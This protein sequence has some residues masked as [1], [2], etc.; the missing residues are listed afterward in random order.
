MSTSQ[1]FVM[2]NRAPRVQIDCDVKLCSTQKNVQLPCAMGPTAQFTVPNT[3]TGATPLADIDGKS[4]AEKEI[5][6]SHDTARDALR[7]A[8]GAQAEPYD[9][10]DSVLAELK[11]THVPER[12]NGGAILSG[13]GRRGHVPPEDRMDD[14]PVPC[15]GRPEKALVG[16]DRNRTHATPR[17]SAKLADGGV[18]AGEVA[19]GCTERDPEALMS[20]TK[21]RPSASQSPFGTVSTSRPDRDSLNRP[22]L[23]MAVF[24]DFSGRAARGLRAVG[25]DLAARPPILLDVDTVEDVIASFAT[26]LTLPI[27]KDGARIEVTLNELDDLHP[28]ELYDSVEIFEALSG[29][30]QQLGTGTMAERAVAQLKGWSETYGKP[31]QLPRRSAA[32]SVPPN[33]KLSDFQ[34]LIGD[35][36]GELTQAS[37]AEDLIARIVGPHVLK[38]PDVGAE[39]MKQSVDEALSTAMRLLLH[40]PDFQ[41]VESQ[42]RALDLMA[43]RIETGSDVEIVLYDISAEELAMDL[44]A[45]EDLSESGIFRL[46]TEALESE[47]GTGGFSALLGLYTLEETPPHA[48]L[49]AR[50]G[51]VAA[52][53]DAPFFAAMTPAYLETAKADRHPLVIQAW[54]ALRALPE[55]AYLGLATPRFLL[56]Q[57]YG[58]K[59][60]PCSSFNFEEFTP[61]EG[62]SGMLW[63]NPVVLVAILLAATR[64]KDGK[65][66]D[67]GSVMSLDDMPFH[68]FTDRYG[69]QIALPCTERN[70]T[71][72]P[73][74]H[75]LARGFMPVFW[76]KGRNEVRLGS[77]RA[78]S[79]D[80]IAGPW[81]DTALTGKPAPSASTLEMDVAAGA[82]ASGG[83]PDDETTGGESDLDDLP[84][85]LDEE[86]DPGS[87]DMDPDTPPFDDDSDLDALL[88]DFD[89]TPSDDDEDDGEM[90]PELAALL[91]GL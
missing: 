50:I 57:P 10:N 61:Q 13:A 91:E 39:A 67:L 3:L 35:T 38:A 43:R 73:A 15:S 8:E 87:G 4:R 23:R 80:M 20:S 60:E 17:Q 32:T 2:R 86:G 27:G 19:G 42:W 25:A 41:V 22:R 28:D 18:H 12:A 71:S 70:L 81:S 74:Q 5:P 14:I 1:N 77:F 21:R 83:A 16:T 53:V 68:F 72:D 85:G 34:A 75:T 48:E 31:V 64:M 65:A 47:A 76:V 40:H 45:Q 51:Q 59:S 30:R 37:P 89:D 33:L 46:L 78:L 54:D 7:R 58:S 44:A 69:D 66:M 82:A 55:A 24:G 84:A 63:A 36:S 11:K 88:A 26:T 6:H 52:H 62:L 56:R 29:L 49:L 79:G 90:D 9:K